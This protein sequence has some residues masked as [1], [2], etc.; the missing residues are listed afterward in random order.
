MSRAF[1]TGAAGFAGSYL[2]EALLVRG[3]EVCG[4]VQ[5][6]TSVAHLEAAQHGPNAARLHLIEGDLLDPGGMLAAVQEWQPDHLYHLAGQASVRQSLE[7]PSETFRINVLGTQHLLE[8]ACRLANRPRVLLVSSADV[9]GASA[10]GGRAVTEQDPLLPLSPYGSSKAAAEWLGRRYANTSDLSLVLVRPFPHT[11]P[12]QTPQ[13]VFPSLARQLAEMRVGLRPL[14]L[15]VG[16]LE[17]RRD[18]GDV[19]DVA[20]AY[21]VA[22][23]RGESGA[24]YNIC[25]GQTPSIREVL[26]Y[27]MA[28][29]GTEIEIAVEPDRLRAAD[30]E[31]LTGNDEAFRRRTAWTPE[32][33]LAQTLQDLLAFWETRYR[34]LDAGVRHGG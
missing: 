5:P 26:V 24:V 30:L 15:Q 3:D 7:D 13:F 34:S 22:L 33:P 20:R 2:T 19:R 6:G 14:R 4:L 10:E 28:L 29:V 27:L 23:E 31:V 18:L 32:I 17:A 9:Y 8:A 11:G 25:S 16:N 1:V 21:I 12:R